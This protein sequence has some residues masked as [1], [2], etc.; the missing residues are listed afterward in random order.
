MCYD[1]FYLRNIQTIR[2]RRANKKRETS[3]WYFCMLNV[4]RRGSFTH[5]A[6]SHI[7]KWSIIKYLFYACAF[8]WVM[9]CQS[10]SDCNEYAAYAWNCG[11]FCRLLRT[12]MHISCTSD[13]LNST[14]ASNAHLMRPITQKHTHDRHLTDRN[15]RNR[16]EF[17]AKA[18][19][20]DLQYNQGN[21][22]CPMTLMDRSGWIRGLR[23]G[24]Q[25]SV[26]YGRKHL[27]D[28][29]IWINIHMF[30]MY[31]DNSAD[32]FHNTQRQ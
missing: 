22:K 7:G 4:Q 26:H 8:P 12:T 30:L 24:H 9:A 14:F 27:I 11:L 28:L 23:C 3:E 32:K 5:R 1:S 6:T 25:F 2:D 18:I 15:N 21:Q 10:I 20:N 16:C 31:L 29:F 13:L 19:D 17:T